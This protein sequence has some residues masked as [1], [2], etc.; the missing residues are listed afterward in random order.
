MSHFYKYPGIEHARDAY[1]VVVA[2]IRGGSDVSVD[3]VVSAGY[4]LVGYGLSIYPGQPAHTESLQGEM[5]AE[6][7]ADA[8]ESAFEEKH[9]GAESLA[10]SLVGALPWS[11]IVPILLDFIKEWL[12]KKLT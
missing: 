10:G 9:G 2:A 4:T 11:V 1:P 5:T 12:L 3:E 7:A 6:Q 8:L